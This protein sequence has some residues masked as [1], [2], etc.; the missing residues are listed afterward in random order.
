MLSDWPNSWRPTTSTDELMS[1]CCSIWTNRIH[2]SQFRIVSIRGS[3][4]YFGQ[5]ALPSLWFDNGNKWRRSDTQDW[6]FKRKL[7]L[8]VR[9]GKRPATRNLPSREKILNFPVFDN[10]S[11]ILI[12]D[13]FKKTYK[14]L[15]YNNRVSVHSIN[16]MSVPIFSTVIVTNYRYHFNYDNKL[17]IV[18]RYTS[19]VTKTS[20]YF[21]FVFI[22]G[23][24]PQ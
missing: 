20:L 9:N 4:R 12:C 18:G 8:L 16:L 11:L 24:L 5:E 13:L 15:P 2:I 6:Q 19:E 14:L 23:K 7:I 3:F 21:Y 10:S 1:L 22:A 17:C